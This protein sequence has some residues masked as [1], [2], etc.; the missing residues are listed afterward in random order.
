MDDVGLAS[1]AYIAWIIS[2]LHV[3]LICA[4]VRSA[5]EVESSALCHKCTRRKKEF[6][7]GREESYKRL[8][9]S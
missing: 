1:I 4:L 8:V 2:A 7:A 3:A 5:I 6:R 9:R